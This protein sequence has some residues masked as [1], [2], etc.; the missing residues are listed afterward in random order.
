MKS[1]LLA[2]LLAFGATQ[3]NSALA[4]DQIK[5]TGMH[6][7]ACKDSIEA[8]FKEKA[9]VETVVIKDISADQ[10]TGWLTLT[11]KPGKTLTDEQVKEIVKLKGFKTDPSCKAAGAAMEKPKKKTI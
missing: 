8:A 10:K 11:Y 7:E 6:C 5:V 2:L 3:A 9:E 4:C 1:T